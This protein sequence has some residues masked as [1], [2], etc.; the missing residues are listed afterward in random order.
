MLTLPTLLKIDVDGMASPVW[1]PGVSQQTLSLNAELSA[2]PTAG[3]AFPQAVYQRSMKPEF[4]FTSYC[5]DKVLET[6]GLTGL[7]LK[8][9]TLGK[10]GLSIYLLKSDADCGRIDAGSVHSVITATAGCGFLTRLSA[11]TGEDVTADVRFVLLSTDGAAA[12]ISRAEGVAAPG[13]VAET[14]FALG[15]FT[16]GGNTISKLTQCS[17]DF[18]VNAEALM[19]DSA[20]TPTDL[21][22]DAIAPVIEGTT[23]QTEKFGSGAGQIPIGGLAAAVADSAIY[24]RKRQAGVGS[25]VADATAEHIKLQPTGLFSWVDPISSSN[26]RPMESSFR[27]T[28]AQAADGTVPIVVS[29]ATAIT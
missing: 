28:T 16:V 23:H 22:V 27:I 29:T 25:Y 17:V 20:V 24:F 15:P 12:A 7:A 21:V 19:V 9:A 18:G 8:T 4:T 14:R 26:N 10:T 11:N 1:I 6:I 3:S 13:P 2:E 5:I